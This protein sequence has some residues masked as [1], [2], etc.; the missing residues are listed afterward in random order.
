MVIVIYFNRSILAQF[1]SEKSPRKYKP[2]ID[3]FVYVQ[4]IENL[5]EAIYIVHYFEGGEG[6]FG[7]G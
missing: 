7:V 4:N 6:S 2:S 3:K 1:G 5:L